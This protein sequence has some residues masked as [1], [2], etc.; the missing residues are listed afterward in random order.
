MFLLC[1]YLPGRDYAVQSLWHEGELIQAKT[2]ER[3]EYLFGVLY[4]D[5]KRWKFKAFWA[6]DRDEE[7]YNLLMQA[8][9]KARPGQLIR[10]ATALTGLSE[11]GVRGA[12]SS[13]QVRS[14]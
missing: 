6:H 4:R 13:I 14:R 1:E 5:R 8:A 3:L 11:A 2:C 7:R 9:H 10:M 12:P